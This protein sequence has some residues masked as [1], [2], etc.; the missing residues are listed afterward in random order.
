VTRSDGSAQIERFIMTLEVIRF[1]R[2][3]RLVEPMLAAGVGWQDVSAQ[4]TSAMPSVAPAHDARAF[5]G[6]CAAGG[7]LAFALASRLGVVVEAEVLLFRPAV[8]V[9]VGSSQAARLD[10]A[11]LF[12]H[13]GLLARF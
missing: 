10:G 13:G 9:Q 5:T 7:G 8:T 6:L 2:A 4:G 12:V 1:F 11:T 3:G